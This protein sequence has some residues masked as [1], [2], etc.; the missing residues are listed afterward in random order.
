MRN[1]EA[2][3]AQ[4]KAELANILYGRRPEEIAAIEADA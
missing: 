3:L 4:A 1:A 2:A